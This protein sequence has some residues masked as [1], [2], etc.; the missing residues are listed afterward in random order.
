MR[1]LNK[2]KPTK[3]KVKFENGRF[4]IS[5]EDIDAFKELVDQLFADPDACIISSNPITINPD[6]S[7]VVDPLPA[8]QPIAG[9]DQEDKD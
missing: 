7:I 8:S 9:D 5:Q 4:V 2:K 3:Q 1:V 6:G